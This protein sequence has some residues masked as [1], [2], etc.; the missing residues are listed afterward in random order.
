MCCIGSPPEPDPTITG[1]VSAFL[2]GPQCA[3]GLYDGD[4]MVSTF[5]SSRAPAE[6]LG[7]GVLDSYFNFGALSSPGMDPGMPDLYA[8][9]GVE[10]LSGGALIQALRG[11]LGVR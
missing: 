4:G 2:D 8:A 10:S 6:I 11:P 5:L 3:S 9:F 7:S 1:H